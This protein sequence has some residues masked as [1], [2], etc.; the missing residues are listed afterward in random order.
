[1]ILSVFFEED[2]KIEIREFTLLT[3]M[4][5]N[6]IISLYRSFFVVMKSTTFQFAIS[7]YFSEKHF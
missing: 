1:M 2:N 6:N 3:Y 7:F 5:G 4:E